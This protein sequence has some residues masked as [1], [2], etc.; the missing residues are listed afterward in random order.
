MRQAQGQA[1]LKRV[2]GP[3]R[4]REAMEEICKLELGR[5]SATV[6]KVEPGTIEC[7]RDATLRTELSCDGVFFGWSD[8]GQSR[9]LESR[10]PENFESVDD[11]AKRVGLPPLGDGDTFDLHALVVATCRL[12]RHI[13]QGGSLDTLERKEFIQSLVVSSSRG[14]KQSL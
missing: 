12:R 3:T 1:G 5:W 8:N 4:R 13:E 7:S 11:W 6:K 2:A 9:D 10:D 14:L